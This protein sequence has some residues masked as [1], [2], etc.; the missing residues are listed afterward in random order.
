[1][2]SCIVLCVLVSSFN[3]HGYAIYWTQAHLWYKK[4]IISVRL[5]GFGVLAAICFMHFAK[6]CILIFEILR[7]IS[8]LFVINRCSVFWCSMFCSIHYYRK[9]TIDTLPCRYF[10]KIAFFLFRQ[11]FKLLMKPFHAIGLSLHLLKA[12]ENKSF[13]DVFSGQRKRPVTQNRLIPH[14]YSHCPC[15]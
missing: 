8:F 1:M 9:S 5:L 14:C 13:S 2:A 6:F 4:F 12:T 3:S 15:L 7:L 11:I 10:H